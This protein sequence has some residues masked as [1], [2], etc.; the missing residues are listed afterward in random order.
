MSDKER[1]DLYK[2]YECMKSRLIRF[3]SGCKYK[4]RFIR[5]YVCNKDK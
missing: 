2:H 5:R 3:A 1:F 4:K